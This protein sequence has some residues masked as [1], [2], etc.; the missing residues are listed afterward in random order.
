[1]KQ[2]SIIAVIAVIICGCSEH[3]NV[4][5]TYVYD[6]GRFIVKT[7]SE[8]DN[9]EMSEQNPSAKATFDEIHLVNGGKYV[10]ISGLVLESDTLILDGEQHQL[11]I[12]ESGK[13][14]I[15]FRR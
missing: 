4:I 9:I 1:M 11:S 13:N 3:R 10:Y 15:W 12:S 6:E 8:F 7:Q 2:Y 5:C 14:I